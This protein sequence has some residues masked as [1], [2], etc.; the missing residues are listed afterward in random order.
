MK[1]R[2]LLLLI[3][4]LSGLFSCSE[5]SSPAILKL[6]KTEIS[7]KVGEKE[8][9]AVTEA[10]STGETIVWASD[11]ESVAT[12][13]YGTVTAF[14]SGTATITATLGNQV[15]QCVVTVPERTYQLVWSD[16]F[17][18][19]SLNTD[20]WTH[21]IGTGSWGWG[22]NEAQYYTNRADNIRVED[23]FL[24]IE[25]RKEDYEGS[26]YTSARIKSANKQSFTYGKIEV[27]LQV[28]SGIGTW[29]A[30]W[31]LGTDGGW[32]D[33]GEIDIMEHVGKESR[34]IHCALHT[35]NK[36][37]M[38]GQNFRASQTL[39]EDVADN[40]HVI[41][42]EWVEKE[43]MG[44]DRMHIYVDSIKTVTFAET[45]QLQDSGDW[46]FNTPFYLIINLALGGNWGGTID[47]RMFNNPVLY[48]LDYI[49]VYQFQ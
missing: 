15:A 1:Y 28:P 6:D 8:T 21:E 42:L 12:V 44:F 5:E 22:N 29:P 41:T 35:K 7:L 17:D 32:P 33:C 40:F 2:V 48:K 16:E 19:T 43:F 30:F 31:M 34:K 37:G 23:G 38:N 27:R 25:A 45:P 10:P 18:G 36:N 14:G 3:F 26:Q 47:D 24:I 20:N 9:I 49:R 4:I 39:T 13:F 11:D 46:P